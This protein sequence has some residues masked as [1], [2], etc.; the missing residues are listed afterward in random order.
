MENTNI[1]FSFTDFSSILPGILTIV[2]LWFIFKKANVPA[3]KSIFPVYNSYILCKISHCVK[4]FVAELL[5]NIFLVIPSAIVVL[6][7]SFGFLFFVGPS[8]DLAITFE[9]LSA[10]FCIALVVLIVSGILS[11]VV[12][13]L[14]SKEIAKSFG[15]STGFAIGLTFLPVVFLLIMAF[16]NDIQYI[17]QIDESAFK[18]FEDDV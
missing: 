7:S 16:S 18:A 15:Q 1:T 8:P 12:S 5:I 11:V 13:F 14:K 4:Y 6:V 3:W 10:F 9:Q 2:A 17:G